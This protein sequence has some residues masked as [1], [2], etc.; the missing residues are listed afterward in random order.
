MI[1]KNNNKIFITQDEKTEGAH[2]EFRVCSGQGSS[3]FVPIHKDTVFFDEYL[4]YLEPTETPNGG[5]T[6]DGCGINYY[7]RE[8]AQ[9]MCN[10]IQK[11]KPQEYTILLDWLKN[12]VLDPSKN[13]F[14]LFGV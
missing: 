1:L 10:K 8:Q 14:Y 12:N 6:F 9:I 4:K 13:G 5:S 11:D 7:T 3:L 2:F